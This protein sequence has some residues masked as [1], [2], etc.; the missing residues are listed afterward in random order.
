MVEI[1]NL[2]KS[3]GNSSVNAVEDLSI[4]LRPGKIYGFL[5][6]NGAGKSTTIKCLVGIYPFQ[7][8]DIIING[9]SIKTNPLETKMQIGY[10]S[11]NHA[12][13]ERLTGREYVNHIA[14]LYRVS[15]SDLE[16]RCSRL[17]KIFSL[18]SWVSASR[19]CKTPGATC[20]I[21]SSL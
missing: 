8:G 19:N 18:S 12:V 7:H 5:G 9:N 21:T 1:K 3:Y 2:T 6:P 4:S 11:D 10:V 13:F 16:E 14:N 15:A 20:S 17:L